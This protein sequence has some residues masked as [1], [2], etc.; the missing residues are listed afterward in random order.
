M[1][2]Q[3]NY[4]IFLSRKCRYCEEFLNE[5]YRNDIGL[6]RKFVKIDVENREIRLPKYVK[7]VPTIIVPINGKNSLLSG[8]DVFKWLDAISKTKIQ[9]QHDQQMNNPM[10]SMDGNPMGNQT[11]I[12]DFDPVSTSFSDNF[13]LITDNKNGYTLLDGNMGLP[14]DFSFVDSRLNASNN[15]NANVQDYGNLTHNQDKIK[16]ESSKRLLEDIQAQ[17]DRDVPV[18]SSRIGGGPQG[19]PPPQSMGGF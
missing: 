3:N 1:N 10:V 18:Q 12:K 5:L 13:S 7:E 16:E 15:L 9:K 4:I 14:K 8:N 17:R 11:G 2:R 6:Y 19:P